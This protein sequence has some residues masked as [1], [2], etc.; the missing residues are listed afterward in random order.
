MNRSILAVTVASL[1]SYA[2]YS[3]AQ[4]AADETM[5]VLAR[6]ENV[7]TVADVP[8]N[9]TII[10]RDEIESSGAKSLESLLRGRAGIQI[11]DSNSGSAFSL[12]GFSGEQAS[13]NTLVLLDGRRLNSQDI[14]A[15]NLNFVQLDDIESIEVLS[16]SAGVLYGDQ[17]VGGV[18]NIVTR[19]SKENRVGV[20]ASYGSF[21]SKVINASAS[22][23][24]DDELSYRFSATQNNSDNYRDH[25]ASENGS[26]LAR[27]NYEND[28]QKLFVE[29]AYYDSDREYA[30][31][32]T[33]EQFKD[34][35]TQSS[36]NE[37]NHAITR[38]V[39]FGYNQDISQ[40]W[41]LKNEIIFDDTDESGFAS[42]GKKKADGGQIFYAGQVEG[43]FASSHGLT[44]IILGLDVAKKHYDYL[45]KWTDRDI[46]QNSWSVY[47]RYT[48][49]LTDALSVN[50]GGRYATVEDDITDAAQFPDG[51]A[52]DENATAYEVALN[53]VVNDS[54]RLYV[55]TESNFRFAKVSEQSFTLPGVI[56]LKPQKGISNELGW[57]LYNENYSINL[58]LFNLELEDEIVYATDPASGSG[59]NMNADASTRNGAG[60]S[61]SFYVTEQFQVS[62]EYN[63][64][65]AEFTEGENKGNDVA[66]VAN[67]TGKVGFNYAIADNINLYSDAVYTGERYQDGD[68][69]NNLDKLD[70]YW[71]VN[72]ALNYRVSDLN[73][74]L[75]AD[76]LLNEKYASYVFYRGYY[77]G[78]EQAY[79][80][81]AAY[82]F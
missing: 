76:N 22:G 73:I 30:G 55:R 49:P 15:P 65:D 69:S 74:S 39:R 24:I 32:L 4:Q 42:G 66:W 68:N 56:G 36:S 43:G 80:L 75:R 41:V 79:Y 51:Q 48:H 2:P 77:S 10:T 35:P 82:E 54:M 37:Y 46:E 59:A 47:G 18:I 29:I 14:V 13:S 33:E 70:S 63:Y 17:A 62:A 8:S 67:H 26:I 81:S 57:N 38:V 21:N 71:L 78:N 27:V 44:N 7:N 53:Y 16:G 12:R 28:T 9:V 20:S 58:N 61:G 72:L 6:S 45:G 1:L 60:L 19:S 31:S 5:V 64:I 52:I 23:S 50:L 11:S 40:A 34:D 3:Q 25:N